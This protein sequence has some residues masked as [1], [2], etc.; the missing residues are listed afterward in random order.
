MS[1][2]RFKSLF[3][4]GPLLVGPFTTLHLR[5]KYTV[6]EKISCWCTLVHKRTFRL[7]S[8]VSIAQQITKVWSGVIGF[9]LQILDFYQSRKQR[10]F[11]ESESECE[12]SGHESKS[13]FIKSQIYES[14]SEFDYLNSSPLKFL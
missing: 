7:D 2:F 9:F 1:G 10:D 5:T 6:G 4:F 12:S 8:R 11:Y 13:E 14:E 3:G